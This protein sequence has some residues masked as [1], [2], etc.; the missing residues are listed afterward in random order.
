MKKNVIPFNIIVKDSQMTSIMQATD[1]FDS[2]KIIGQR[3]SIEITYDV[4]AE[5][6]EER[7]ANTM[8]ALVEAYSEF[9]KQEIVF[10]DLSI[11]IVN[12]TPYV[13]KR[14]RQVSDGKKSFLFVDWLK[15]IG[16]DVETTQ[17]MYVKSIKQP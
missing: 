14:V 12:S 2:G 9:G 13:D 16:Y 17:D 6:T 5:I 7:I 3:Q 8:K 11:G 1:L 10:L 15:H 4:D